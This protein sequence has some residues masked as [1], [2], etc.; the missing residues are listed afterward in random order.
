MRILSVNIGRPVPN[1]VGDGRDYGHL[2]GHHKA[3]VDQIA[4]ADPGPGGVD[5]QHPSGVAGDFVGTPRHHGGS[6]KAVYAVGREDLDLWSQRLGR[7][8]PNGWMGENLTTTGWDLN[9][10]VIGETWAV[11]DAV[12]QV[13]VARIPCRT[14]AHVAQ[15]QGWLKEFTA[16]GGAGTYLRVLHPGTITPG[17]EVR[18]LE[19]PE[20]GVTMREL[21][22]ARTIRPGLGGRVLDA[23]DHLPEQIVAQL[24]SRSLSGHA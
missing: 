10:S 3:P 15:R 9:A 24:R 21:F 18:R 20:H 17:D 7:D 13:S 16:A 8:L 23:A 12:L 5:N 22:W 6:D 14:F 4:V 1:P 11:A 19:V 2:T